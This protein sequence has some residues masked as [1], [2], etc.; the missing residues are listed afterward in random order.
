MEDIHCYYYLHE[1]GEVIWKPAGVT[2]NA[3]DYFDSPFVKKLWTIRTFE[4]QMRF[5]LDLKEM[6][7]KGPKGGIYW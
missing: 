2:V 4:D 5:M 7:L 1:N 3:P 6:G